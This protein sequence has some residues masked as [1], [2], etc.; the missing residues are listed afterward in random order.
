MSTN[1]NFPGAIKLFFQRYADFHGR[2]TRAEY[3]YA[4]L[5]N[6]IIAFVFYFIP[7]II[8][9]LS[10]LVTFTN[11]GTA[12]DINNPVALYS[13]IISGATL[14]LLVPVILFLTYSL[15][16]LI[17]NLAI[18]TRRLHDMGRPGWWTAV[19]AGAP[20]A[21]NVISLF[22]DAVCDTTYSHGAMIFAMLV[23]FVIGM[24]VLALGI[25]GIVWACKPSVPDN[26]YGSD[27]Y[28]SE[29]NTYYDY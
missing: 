26:E 27:P 29:K 1:V 4:Q 7:L 14:V 12:Q 8:M 13:R 19:F 21:L 22:L 20:I 9:T 18:F 5:F 3:W 11:S 24:G 15:A 28:A 25:V 16:T 10:M 17:P 23:R 2:S 6:A